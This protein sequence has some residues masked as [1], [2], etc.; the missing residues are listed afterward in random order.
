M[1]INIIFQRKKKFL[2]LLI[3]FL[4]QIQK[5]KVIK[6]ALCT[7]AKE[8]N[9]YVKE[10]ISYYIKLG[11]DKIFIYDDNNLDSENIID[12]INLLDEYKNYV[13]IYKNKSIIKHQSNAFTDCYRKNY[14]K[15]DFFLMLDMD[16]F[17]VTVKKTL[18]NYLSQPIF[19][20]CD[21]IKIHWVVPTDNNLLHYDNRSLFKRFKK[22]YR[23]SIHIKSI[24]RGN[25][26]NLKYWVH[27]PS[28]S[29]NKNITCDS[30]GKTI[31]SNSVLIETVSHISI[32]NAYLIHFQFKSTEEFI[33]K[34]K[35]G[36]NDWI[37]QKA[38]FM[39]LIEYLKFN[40]I[41]KSKID[42]IEKELKI[43]LTKYRN[44]IIKYNK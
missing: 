24:I 20:K 39:K 42:Y 22:P 27:S 12:E 10:F 15:Y 21:F 35:R 13:H 38:H 18:K 31:K 37:S 7:M 32:K 14:N 28:Y 11:V 44:E 33:K 9:L 3:C 30:N 1:I 2:L 36:Y 43:N 17:L 5:K 41:T 4:F 29:P 6:I 16:E 40:E 34:F 19:N 25:I 26:S 8:E 23:K